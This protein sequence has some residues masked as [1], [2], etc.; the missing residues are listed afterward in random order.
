MVSII[1][2]LPEMFNFLNSQRSTVWDKNEA[3]MNKQNKI[4]KV[5]SWE[6]SDSHGSVGEFAI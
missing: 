4:H 2:C 5:A 6:T 3:K 1:A